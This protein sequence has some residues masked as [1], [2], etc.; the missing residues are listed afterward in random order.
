M[1]DTRRVHTECRATHI[2]QTMPVGAAGPRWLLSLVVNAAI[3]PEAQEQ[4]GSSQPAAEPVDGR[5]ATLLLARPSGST[6]RARPEMPHGRY[7]LAT[8][9]KLLRY[10]PAPEHVGPALPSPSSKKSENITRPRPCDAVTALHHQSQ[11]PSSARLTNPASAL[12]R[13]QPT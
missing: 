1:D 3:G 4:Q 8:A 10:R 6:S 5:T 13:P 11:S 2:G 12:M 9:I 7:V